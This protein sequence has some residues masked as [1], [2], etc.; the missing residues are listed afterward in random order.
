MENASSQPA[1]PASFS[2]D[3]ADGRA[4]LAAIETAFEAFNRGD[5]AAFRATWADDV[6]AVINQAA[7]HVWTGAN[8]VEQWLAD[9][10]AG[11]KD[12]DMRVTIAMDRCG[13]L[14]ISG[15]VAFVVLEVTMRI[16]IGDAQV[17]EHGIQISNLI[18]TRDGWRVRA[19]AYG[20]L[21]AVA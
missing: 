16:S 20:G 21:D 8:A 17:V 9:S 18:R 12:K 14:A 3:A 1:L 13:K 2:G 11:V 19:L 15:D 4:I 7:P 5:M 10:A 6:A